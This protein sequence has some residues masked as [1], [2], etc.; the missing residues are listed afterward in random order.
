[1]PAEFWADCEG[2]SRGT[3]AGPELCTI[4][5]VGQQPAKGDGGLQLEI[6]TLEK[7]REGSVSQKSKAERYAA[8][9]WSR[10]SKLSHCSGPA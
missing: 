5:T 6:G 2:V 1:M 10:S 7:G 9:G 4:V 8:I 3:A